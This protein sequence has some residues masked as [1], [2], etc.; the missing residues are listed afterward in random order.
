MG[1]KPWNYFVPFEASVEVALEKLRQRVFEAGDFFGSEMNPAAL[2]E[3]MENMGE[4][5]TASI[6]DMMQI[7]DSPE[8]FSVYPLSDSRLKSL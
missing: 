4:A 6:L 1:G 3:A 5:G 8:L 2:E 7:S